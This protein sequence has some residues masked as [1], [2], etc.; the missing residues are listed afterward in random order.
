[1][2]KYD[3]IPAGACTFAAPIEVGSNGEGSKTAPFNILARSSK[4]IEHWF[5]GNVVHD[6]AGAFGKDRIPIDYNH[7]EVIGFA[8]KR[9]VTS[10][11]V[12]LS[13]A[14][15]SVAE[16]DRADTVM[17]Q[18]QAGIPFEASIN[19]GGDGIKIEEVAAGA[20][21]FVNGY[22]FDGPGVIIREYPL[23]GCAFCP[24]GADGN[25]E[26]ELFSEGTKFSA[27]LITQ[28]TE[29]AEMSK[30]EQADAT[31]AKPAVELAQVEAVEAIETAPA[32]AVQAVEE[33]VAELAQADVEAPEAEAEVVEPVQFSQDELV[34]MTTDFGQDITM[35]VVTN[36][37][38]YAD[39]QELF[40]QAEKA[41]L[42]ALRAENAELKAQKPVV[43]GASPVAFADGEKRKSKMSFVQGLTAKLNGNK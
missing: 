6:S 43:S 11:G 31:E 14:L 3:S 34:K 12:R 33:D 37:G 23:R 26:T 8:N 24:Y 29:V 42:V 1:M 30:P 9:E 21:A 13:G 7:D 10:E 22:D 36:G 18:A 28:K 35:Q 15:V 20:T 32:E 27:Q 16:N 41:E 4:P 25:T 5:W 17:K 39:A 19:F 40:H 2:N 38:N